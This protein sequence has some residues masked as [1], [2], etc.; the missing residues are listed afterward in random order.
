MHRLAEEELGGGVER[1]AEEE[2]GEIDL[3]RPVFGVDGEV[4]HHVLDVRFFQLEVGDLVARELRAEES[5]GVFPA[6][7]VSGNGQ[8]LKRER[9]LLTSSFHR[10]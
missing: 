3:R 4:L 6:E 7:G 8:G 2:R 1:Q 9:I 10:W 5:A